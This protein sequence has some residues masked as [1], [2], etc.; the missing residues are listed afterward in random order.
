MISQL[1]RQYRGASGNAEARAKIARLCNGI[2]DG[3][4]GSKDKMDAAKLL[5]E[6]TKT[7]DLVQQYESIANDRELAVL[8]ECQEVIADL[9]SRL[10]S[11]GRK[12]R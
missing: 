4:Y 1:R 7:A 3:P 10:S 6:V 5:L 8:I 2:L 9:E 12:K 11:K